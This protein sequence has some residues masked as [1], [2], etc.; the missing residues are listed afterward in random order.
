[1]VV[2]FDDPPTAAFVSIT[3]NGNGSVGCVM[4]TVPVAGL[5][6]GVNYFVPDNNFT[7][8]GAQEARIPAGSSLG[9]ATGST[10]HIT[11]NCDNGLSTSM[12]RVY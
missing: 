3:N 11:V 10:F 8:A 5:A 1:L 7:V 12:D 6:A 2:R 4:K 9:P